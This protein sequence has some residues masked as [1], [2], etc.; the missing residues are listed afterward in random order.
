MELNAEQSRSIAS[1]RAPVWRLIQSLTEGPQ[2]AAR[3]Q[4]MVRFRP[5][6][7]DHYLAHTVARHH[8]DF[9]GRQLGF[10]VV[11]VRSNQETR[12][13]LGLAQIPAPHFRRGNSFLA[14]DRQDSGGKAALARSEE[15]TS[16]LQSPCNLVCRLLLEKTS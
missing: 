10:G 9:V 7:L 16:E 12:D 8:L 14:L 11:L 5:E 1:H 6:W 3:S 15:H 2:H 4:S 13:D